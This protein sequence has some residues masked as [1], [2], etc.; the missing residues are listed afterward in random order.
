MV[1]VRTALLILLCLGPRA[2][3]QGTP[4]GKGAPAAADSVQASPTDKQKTSQKFGATPDGY[5]FGLGLQNGDELFYVVENEF[6]DSGGVPP[7][8]SYTTSAK[9]KRTIVQRVLRAGARS[10]VATQPAGAEPFMI[11]WKCDRYEVQEQGMRDRV[12]FD[13]LR[14]LYP[15]PTLYELGT[16]PGSEVTF[17]I[18]PATAKTE[19]WNILPGKVAGSAARKNPSST[20]GRCRLSV[21]N[22]Q[23]LADAMGP[24]WMPERPVKVGD[25]W[26]RKIVE[27]KKN[28][29]NLITEVACTFK[30]IRREGDAEIAMIDIGGNIHLEPPPEPASQPAPTPRPG[31]T[32]G[33]ATTAPARAQSKRVFKLDKAVCSGAV[34][35][36]MTHGRLVQ[37]VLRRE[38]GLVAEV[39]TPGKADKMQLRTTSGHLLKVKT[40]LT[41]P[42]KPV[43]IG[44]PKAPKVSPEDEKGMRPDRPSPNL[45]QRPQLKP[46]TSSSQPAGESPQ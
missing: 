1:F 16:I 34:D 18:Q 20:T 14:D 43:I 33:P 3:A 4:P 28:F 13:S 12:T 8:L 21:E 37:M 30:S 32:T 24:F 9:D 6:R 10:E 5:V 15:P 40:S 45:R 29:G 44:G 41:A 26:T 23:E 17:L 19:R 31:T 22:L 11:Q 38:T 42:P 46:T 7:L 35:F 27:S 36:D 39:E 25:H 2:V